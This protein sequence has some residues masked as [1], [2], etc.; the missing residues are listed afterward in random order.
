[1]SPNDRHGTR[2]KQARRDL[3]RLSE[4]SEK[5]MGAGSAEPPEATDDHIEIL[6]RRIGRALGYLIATGLLIYLLATY[7]FA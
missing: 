7:V 2:A 3:E 1:M 5:L 4:Q 6:G